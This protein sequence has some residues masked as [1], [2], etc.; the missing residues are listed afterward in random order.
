ML[1]NSSDE[2]IHINT[3]FW[4]NGPV[5]QAQADTVIYAGTGLYV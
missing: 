2:P 5:F 1:F 4:P 3:P